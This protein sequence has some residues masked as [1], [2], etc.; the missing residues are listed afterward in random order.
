MICSR[1]PKIK[2]PKPHLIF[3]SKLSCGFLSIFFRNKVRFSSKFFS[4]YTFKGNEYQKRIPAPIISRIRPRLF[5]K[6]EEIK[7]ISI[8]HGFIF[9]DKPIQFFIRLITVFFLKQGNI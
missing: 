7:N 9:I 1:K 3:G 6:F 4:G 5:T 2:N 8:G